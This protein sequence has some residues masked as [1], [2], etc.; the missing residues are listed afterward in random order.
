MLNHLTIKKYA[1]TKMSIKN[2][3]NNINNSS[4]KCEMKSPDLS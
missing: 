1:A 2:T 3:Y 4:A